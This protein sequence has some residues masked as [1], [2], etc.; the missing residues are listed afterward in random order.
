MPSHLEKSTN[1]EKAQLDDACNEP[2]ILRNK[3]TKCSVLPNSRSESAKIN[4]IFCGVTGVI[5]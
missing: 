4:H 1:L 3:M 5:Q 2:A